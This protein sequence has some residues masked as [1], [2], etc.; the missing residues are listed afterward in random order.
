MST[1]P[2]QDKRYVAGPRALGAVLP[3]ITRPA[4]RKRSP[5]AATL[6]A[7]WPQIVG[8]AIAAAAAPVRFSSGTL[9]LAAA[10]PVAL[11]LQHLAPELIARLNGHLGRVLIERLRFAP[12]VAPAAR[13]PAPPARPPRAAGFA[14]AQAE[15]GDLPDGPVGE[16]LRSLHASMARGQ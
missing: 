11:E 8:P 15:P 1:P 7:D 6:M 4:F 12:P 2:E 3:A 9:T 16:A 10:G 13:Q 14:E 5:A